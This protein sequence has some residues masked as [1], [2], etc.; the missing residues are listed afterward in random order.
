MRQIGA[1]IQHG[2]RG[3]ADLDRIAL[4]IAAKIPDGD[5]VFA[6]KKGGRGGVSSAIAPLIAGK[7]AAGVEGKHAVLTDD[8]IEA[9]VEDFIVGSCYQ[10][11]ECVGRSAA[12]GV[13]RYD[14]AA[15][16][17]CKVTNRGV[18]RI[19]FNTGIQVLHLPSYR[20]DIALY[21][22]CLVLHGRVQFTNRIGRII[23]KRNVRCCEVGRNNIA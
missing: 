13:S 12:R 2:I 16:T 1:E 6:G 10:H 23:M 21:F 11:I 19:W 4:H 3:D 20:I 18:L 9:K 22:N 14:E 17:G 8:K 15:R 7:T 5:P